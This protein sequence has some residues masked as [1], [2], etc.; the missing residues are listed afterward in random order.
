MRKPRRLAT[1]REV[2]A[3]R[4]CNNEFRPK[5]Q[6]QRFCTQRCRDA[7]RYDTSP[8]SRRPMRA[9]QRPKKA[10]KR[11]LWTGTL[12]SAENGGKRQTKTI[13]YREVVGPSIGLKS[14]RPV[15]DLIGI[16]AELLRKII[17]IECGDS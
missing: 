10:R 14:G 7:Y 16:D 6:V 4:H 5:R 9:S 15:V 13:G 17:E 8:A 2:C 3:Y 11:H 12:R 1:Q